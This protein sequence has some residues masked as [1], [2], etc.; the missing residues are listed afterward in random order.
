MRCITTSN[1]THTP[2]IDLLFNGWT[3]VMLGLAVRSAWEAR[4]GRVVK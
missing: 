1:I 3:L 4:L 2:G